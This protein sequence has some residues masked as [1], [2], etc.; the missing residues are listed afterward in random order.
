MKPMLACDHDPS[1]LQFPLYASPKLDGLRG[2]VHEGRLLSRSL[3]PIP[4][5][6]VS[7]LLSTS[8]LEGF[9]GELIVGSPTA[10]DVYRN[11]SSHIM[12]I[13]KV[14]NFSFFVFDLHN[15]DRGFEK[16]YDVLSERVA[17]FDSSFPIVLW[18]Q[19][20]ITNEDELLAYEAEQ[21]AF[22]YEGLILRDPAGKYKFGRSTTNEGLLLKVKRFSDSEA[23]ILGFDEQMHNTNEAEKNE[24]G[25]TKRSSAKAGLV[26]K[27][28][29]GALHVMDIHSAQDFRIG[30]G[31]D[32]ATRSL[33][34][35]NRKEYIG[36]IIKYKF[37][38]I[39][40]KDLPRHPVFQGFR[41]PRDL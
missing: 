5:R 22:G 31:L 23:E 21:L 11:S 4:N 41:D 12:S 20:W 14:M 35:N 9:D 28:T 3:K 15:L 26:G 34:W 18:D 37:F 24:L 8:K 1:K 39:G 36:K 7:D 16:R 2:L 10:V 27:N 29:L 25:R 40:V 33:I 17:R 13:E 38:S 30:T 6:H 32:D 19:Q